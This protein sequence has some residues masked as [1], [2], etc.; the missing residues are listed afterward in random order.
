M[1]S[2]YLFIN[3]ENSF[4]TTR[5][6]LKGRFFICSWR[7]LVTSAFSVIKNF[8]ERE[9][10]RETQIVALSYFRPSITCYLYAIF[11]ASGHNGKLPAFHSCRRNGRDKKYFIYKI[12]DHWVVHQIESLHKGAIWNPLRFPKSMQWIIKGAEIIP[13]NTQTAPRV[14][15]RYTS[16]TAS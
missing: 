16:P 12:N 2:Q 14:T 7:N 10:Q 8:R 11:Q 13:Q 9:G 5:L 4:C 6:L 1:A 3:V 15:I